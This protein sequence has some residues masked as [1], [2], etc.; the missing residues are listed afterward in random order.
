MRSLT[1]LGRQ[2]HFIRSYYLTLRSC[3][4][5]MQG[6]RMRKV[7]K[8]RAAYRSHRESSSSGNRADFSA[9]EHAAFNRTASSEMIAPA[10]RVN[11][12]SAAF[13]NRLLCTR[14]GIKRPAHTMHVLATCFY[15]GSLSC[16][17]NPSYLPPT[18]IGKS[19]NLRLNSLEKG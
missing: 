2:Q 3:P 16:P 19:L 5:R 18:T 7:R 14:Y 13:L 6:L 17:G 10:V 15:R 8:S 1:G 11:R 9:R 12:L 4:L